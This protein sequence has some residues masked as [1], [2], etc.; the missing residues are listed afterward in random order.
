MCFDSESIL[1]AMTNHRPLVLL[2]GL[3]GR[4]ATE[5]GKYFSSI[6]DV[7]LLT[8]GL[9]SERTNEVQIDLGAA[10]VALIRPAARDAWFSSANLEQERV[11][12]LDCTAPDAVLNNVKFY[13]DRGLSFVLATTGYNRSH[14]DALLER[15][16][17]GNCV[18]APNLAKPIVLLQALLDYGAATFP[19]ALR[20]VEVSVTESHQSNKRDVSG[21]ALWMI[22]RFGK[23]GIHGGEGSIESVRDQTRQRQ[24]GV[25][26]AYLNGHAWHTYKFSIPANLESFDASLS[27]NICG[28]AIYAQGA[29]EAVKFL[30]WQALSGGKGKRFSMVDVL[31]GTNL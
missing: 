25:P 22:E 1:R 5:I 6:Q 2:S 24:L 23:L 28:R 3:P 31:K 16:W 29:L 20:G 18:I 12:V 10:R 11:V 27:H 14:L 26:E 13:L 4:L 8:A 9:C 21:T 19:N 15:N 30:L 17:D 7:E